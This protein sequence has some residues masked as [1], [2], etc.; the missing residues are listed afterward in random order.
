MPLFPLASQTVV[1]FP[2]GASVEVAGLVRGVEYL[3]TADADAYLQYGA[4]AAVNVGLFLP[5]DVPQYFVFGMP[6]S[7]GTNL[8]VFVFGAAGCHVHFTPVQR[9]AGM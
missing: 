7:Q 1:A 3:V 5:V 2:N 8:K 6:D 9:V 4:A